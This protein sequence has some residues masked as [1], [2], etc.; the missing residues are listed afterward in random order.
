MVFKL[1]PRFLWNIKTFFQVKINFKKT[2]INYKWSHWKIKLICHWNNYKSFNWQIASVIIN[3][4]HFSFLTKNIPL[5][6]MAYL[7]DLW[8]IPYLIWSQCKL[9][10][11]NKYQCEIHEC[12]FTLTGNIRNSRIAWAISR[13]K[14]HD[15]KQTQWYW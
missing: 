1:I 8:R 10:T 2:L 7:W 13:E 5:Y 12:L 14:I 6:E 15:W 9:C 11:V 4:R 3:S